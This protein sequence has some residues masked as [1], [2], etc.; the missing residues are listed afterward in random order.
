[1][2]YLF[3]AQIY[4]RIHFPFI[5]PFPSD[6]LSWKHISCL[7]FQEICQQMFVCLFI[8]LLRLKANQ[9]ATTINASS[10]FACLR[11]QAP[12]P[13]FS[14][15]CCCILTPGGQPMRQCPKASIKSH[16]LHY[17]F[18]W[19]IVYWAMPCDLTASEELWSL[20]VPV[21]GWGGERQRTHNGQKIN[22]RSDLLE[23]APHHPHHPG[24]QHH[25]WTSEANVATSAKFYKPPPLPAYPF[26][27]KSSHFWVHKTPGILAKHSE[28]LPS[29]TGGG[30]N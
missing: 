10:G 25:S 17:S 24:H 16:T 18:W 13:T 2:H 29:V 8:S 5:S 26:T 23:E 20:E 14:I 15:S 21:G 19:R 1:M 12:I 7:R 9:N 27:L 28:H 30:K 6:A 4:S 22:T 3:P 11:K